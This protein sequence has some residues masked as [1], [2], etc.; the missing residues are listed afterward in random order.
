MRAL[1]FAGRETAGA[2]GRFEILRVAGA[3]TLSGTRE[4]VENALRPWRLPPLDALE[5][6]G[7]ET[8]KQAVAAN[9]GIAFVSREAAADQL[10]LGKLRSIAVEGFTLRRPFYLLHLVGRPRSVAAR[11]SRLF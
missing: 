1:A 8:L 7:A 5:I 2:N 3:R 10:A 4:V 11:V 9:V 6:G